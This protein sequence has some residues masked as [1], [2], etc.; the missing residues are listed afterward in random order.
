MARRSVWTYNNAMATKTL[1]TVEQFL[2]SPEYLGQDS[3]DGSPRQYELDEGELIEMPSANVRHNYLSSEL[4]FYMK[5]FLKQEKLGQV[6]AETDVRLD[7]NTVYRPDV[8]YWDAEHFAAIDQGTVPVQVIPQ[9]V[10]EIA[11]PSN[12]YQELLRRATKYRRAG[13]HTV[14]IVNDDPLDIQIFEPS[15]RRFVNLGESLTLPELLPGFS[16]EAAQLLPP[17]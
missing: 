7:S 14:L 16:V 6:L 12:S 8:V 11:S 2:Q 17:A 15:G 10:V 1:L 13:V 5:S 9:L 3:L 4:Q